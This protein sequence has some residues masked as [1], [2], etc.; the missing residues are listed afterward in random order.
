MRIPW[1]TSSRL[2]SMHACRH[3]ERPSISGNQW[4]VRFL[5][6]VL[7]NVVRL[8][9]CWVDIV[10]YIPLISLSPDVRISDDQNLLLV[11]FAIF[12]CVRLC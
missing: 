11:L 7:V 9:L 2:I 10:I 4:L 8:P 6:D 12:Q 3:L 5:H 1:L